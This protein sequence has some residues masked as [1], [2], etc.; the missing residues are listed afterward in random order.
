MLRQARQPELREAEE[1]LFF[2]DQNF[3]GGAAAQEAL[4][5][6]MVV[7]DGRNDA[8][9]SATLGKEKV[10]QNHR[11]NDPHQICEQHCGYGI[12]GVSHAHRAEI[13]CDHVESGV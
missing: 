1:K 9:W 13:D 7:Q 11:G 2:H 6:L 8:S 10:G 12:S 5:Q 3:T 4:A